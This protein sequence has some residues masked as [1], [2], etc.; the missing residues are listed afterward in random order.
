MVPSNNVERMHYL[1][2]QLT[3]NE[4]I[5]N[6]QLNLV[7]SENVLSPLVRKALSTDLA[8]RYSSEFYGG[9]NIT[10]NIIDYVR[11]LAKELFNCDFAYI[12]PI[13]GNIC[14]VAAINSL[15]SVGDLVALINMETGGY[16]FE[17]SAFNRKTAFLPF[18][19]EK[20]T[21]DYE[22]I[23]EFFSSN[24]PALTILGASAILYPY[25]ITKVL[26]NINNE[27]QYVVYDGSHVLGLIAGNRFQNPLEDGVPLLFG[28]THKTFP[29]PQGGII[30][31]NDIVFSI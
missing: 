18:D 22:K 4:R 2:S 25:S 15:T 31:S 10:R 20:W 16:P 30:L 29:G 6:S 3:D 28:S 23:E 11:E 9:S 8:G 24:R 7:V 1:S 27:T 17:I 14:D 21:L 19:K 12:T 26:K 5:R 13:S